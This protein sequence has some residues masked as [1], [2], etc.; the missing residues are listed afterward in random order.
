MFRPKHSDTD[1]ENVDSLVVSDYVEE[2]VNEI[3]VVEEVEDENQE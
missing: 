2:G 3:H 1:S